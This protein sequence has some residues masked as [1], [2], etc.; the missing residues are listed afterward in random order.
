M[1]GCDGRRIPEVMKRLLRVAVAAC[2]IV[3]AHTAWAQTAARIAAASDLKFALDEVIEAFRSDSSHAII[4]TYGSS[5]NLF[6]QIA[7]GAPFELFLSADEAYVARLAESGLTVD[8]GTLYAQGRLVLY[9]SEASR[10]VPDA[11]WQDFREA[12]RQGRIRRFA[13]ANFDH[14]PYG[15][16]AREALQAQGLW[17]ALQ[18]RL[19]L[20]EN[21][22]QAAQFAASGSADGGL[23]AAS[24][25]RAPGLSARGRHV[26]VPRQWHAPLRQ[27]MVLMKTASAEVRRFYAYLQG[28]E[29]IDILARHGFERPAP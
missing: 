5:G 15:R 22:S 29:A 27:R 6:R 10:F 28:R 2:A 3:W 25:L 4:V 17:E 1:I 18:P 8:G 9:A 16:A 7:A 13:I 12:I 19:I 23:F 26:P 20:G 21:V 14:A 24:L 11:Q